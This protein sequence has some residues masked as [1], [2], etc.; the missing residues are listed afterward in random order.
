V[1]HARDRLKVERGTSMDE[2]GRPFLGFIEAAEVC[3][4]R[5]VLMSSYSE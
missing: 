3:V 1:V 4:F 2:Y 5:K